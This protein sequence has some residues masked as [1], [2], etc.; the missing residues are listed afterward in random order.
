MGCFLNETNVDLFVV[1]VLK[2]KISQN[3][4]DD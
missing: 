1:N 4:C 3:S 2:D